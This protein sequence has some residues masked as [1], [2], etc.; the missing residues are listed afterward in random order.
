MITIDFESFYDNSFSLSRM[1]TEEYI[2]SAQFEVI[3]VGIK[4]D[5]APAYWVTGSA[6]RRELERLNLHNEKVLAHNAAFDGAIL[7]WKYGIVPKFFFDTM[8]IS[9]PLHQ[10]NVGGS[11]AKLAE[12]YGIGVKGTEVIDAKGKRLEHFTEAQLAE[13]G[14]YCKNDVELTYDL[15]QLVQAQ[16]TPQELFIM[17]MMLRM[18]ICPT[19]E[20]D[21]P[22]LVKYLDEVQRKKQILLERVGEV[23]APELM[24]NQQFAELLRKLGVEPPMKVSLRTGKPALALSKSDEAFKNLQEHEDPRVQTLVAARL[25]IKS[26]I[27]ET[28]TQRFIEIAERGA[29]PIMLNYWGAHTGRASGGEKLNLQNLPR[30]G[31]LRAALKAPEGCVLV[32]VDSAQIEARVV[33]WLAGQ[34]DLVTDFTNGE[35]I[36]SKFASKVYKK[37]INKAEN[38]V[39]RHVGKTCLSAGTKVLTERGWVNIENVCIDDRLWDGEEWVCHEGLVFNGYK[40]TLNMSGVW[41]TPDHLVLCGTQW[42]EA[43]SVAQDESSLYRALALGQENLPLQATSRGCAVGFPR[44]SLR[45][46]AESGSIKSISTTLRT[47]SPPAVT[48]AHKLRRVVKDT[49][50]MLRHWL[51]TTTGH[52][53]LT[54]FPV[55]YRAATYLQ[56]GCTNTTGNGASQYTASGGMTVQRFWCTRR[57]STDGITQCSTWTELTMTEGTSQKISGFA[58]SPTICGT[59]GKSNYYNA[60]SQNL[61]ERLPVYDLANA[62]ARHRFTVMTKRGPVLVHNCI[63]GLG[64]GMGT[65]KFQNT[66]KVGNPSVVMTEA[67][68]RAVVDLYRSS[69]SKIKALWKQ[70]DAALEAMT[71]GR[72]YDFGVPIK[73][74]CQNNAVVLPNGTCIR[75]PE[76]KR[77][78]S[79][80][81]YRNRYGQV[82]IYGGKFVENVVQALARIVVFNQMAKIEQAFRKHPNPEGAT[83]RVVLTVH[84]EVVAVVPKD[85][86]QHWHDYMIEVMSKPANW[87]IGLPIACE[88]AVGANYAECK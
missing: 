71:D 45:A 32:A 83:R 17:D 58:P 19:L 68:A 21:K 35:D 72:E 42:K 56:T 44:Y 64:F 18:F 47:L 53:Y 88:G 69:Y 55:L 15:F 54:A 23:K 30:G 63:L 26:T 9:R 25:G 81:S 61:S 48:L 51:T 20:L 75:Y 7:A 70:A 76:L 8:L 3:G 11:L 10:T 36:Y 34:D 46:T 43:A 84:D 87:A 12:Y 31:T 16:A 2:R 67:E 13:Y 80:F 57:L 40:R 82:H 4:V 79:G 27:E 65:D 5:A 66:L 86:A 24:S 60:K 59:S 38:K 41:L 73:L 14:R 74:K 29:L 33:A 62:G 77:D 37:P 85:E 49:G 22:L 28:R 39:E 52:G 78:E 50:R 1:T 6:V